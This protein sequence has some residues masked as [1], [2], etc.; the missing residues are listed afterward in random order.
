MSKERA[1]GF[2]AAMKKADMQETAK[3]II[4]EFNIC[5]N[6]LGRQFGQVSHGLTNKQRGMLIRKML[7]SK[8]HEKRCQI[9]R[10]L[11]QKGIDRWAAKA[12]TKLEKLEF[13]S[14][15]IGSRMT[16]AL[17]ESEEK[18]WEF[19]GIKYCE[20]MKTE[21]NREV[22][23]LVS[24]R[25]RKDVNELAPD[26]AVLIDLERKKVELQIN[27]LFIY[28]EYQKLVR[29]IPQ[30]KWETYKTSVED[31]IAKPVMK[32]AKGK[33]HSLHGSG[34]E[35]IDALCL[36]WRPFVLEISSPGK[37][38]VG[39]RKMQADINRSGKVRVR[40]LRASSKKEVAEIKSARNDK[41]YRMLVEFGNRID[42]EQLK[43]LDTLRGT[44]VQE[45]PQRVV[46]RRVDK[47][48]KRKVKEIR[49]KNVSNKKLV[50]EIKGE[51]GLYVKELVSGDNGRTRPSV[52]GV[53][54]NPAKVLELD[55]IRIHS[56]KERK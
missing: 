31:V 2:A 14:F 38:R 13:G 25:M 17:V 1:A 43:K 37:R 9:C 16:P 49:W 44:I 41:T 39:M 21:F 7:K 47:I 48:R 50:L 56:T 11:F 10:G 55:V 28:G 51:A 24:G 8:E 34:R 5:D 35:D 32:A 40:H 6:C 19:A 22:G 3:S 33:G 42:D 29:G 53:T 46:H 4:Q 36:G 54:G 45:T 15:L 20:P 18:L 26:V 52:S 30:T 27:P 23:K 12:I